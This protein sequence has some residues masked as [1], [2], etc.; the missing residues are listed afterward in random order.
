MSRLRRSSP[1]HHGQRGQ[2][3]VEFSLAIL[4]FLLMIVALFDVGR[5]VYM[6]NGVSEAAREIAR[7]TAVYPGVTLGSSNETLARLAIQRGLVPDLGT[8]TYTCVKVDGS[9]STNNPCTTDD[10]ARVTVTATYRP[11]SFLG[12]GGPIVLSASSSVRIP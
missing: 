11:I 5:G 10:Y 9:A 3:L 12:M 7:V 6:Y 4:V 8:P 2:A 1:D